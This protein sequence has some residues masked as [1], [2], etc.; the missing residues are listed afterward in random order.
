M[1]NDPSLDGLEL[2]GLCG[3]GHDEAYHTRPV[4][5]VDP[6]T[7]TMIIV[8]QTGCTTCKCPRY[9]QK[10][11]QRYGGLGEQ[12]GKEWPGGRPGQ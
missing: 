3:C 8:S 9:D 1:P 5:R 12:A 6:A 11:A 10:S 4:F 7:Q 2:P